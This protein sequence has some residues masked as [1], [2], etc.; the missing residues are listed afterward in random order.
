MSRKWTMYL[1]LRN[2]PKG[3]AT[4]FPLLQAASLDEAVIIGT[5]IFE[6]LEQRRIVGGRRRSVEEVEE[7]WSEW[8]KTSRKYCLPF[9]KTAHPSRLFQRKS[10]GDLSTL[11]IQQTVVFSVKPGKRGADELSIQVTASNNYQ[12]ARRS[13]WGPKVNSVA[14]IKQLIKTANSTPACWSLQESDCALNE[15][16]EFRK[17]HLNAKTARCWKKTS[18]KKKDKAKP[19]H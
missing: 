1:V 9:S 8:L 12:V 15:G 3:Q 10:F 6:K 5:E 11:A 13:V 2:V 16:C 7:Y 4:I 17:Y 19:R 14:Q 18:S